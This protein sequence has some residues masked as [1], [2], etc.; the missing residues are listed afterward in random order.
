MSGSH[1]QELGRRVL[2]LVISVLMIILTIILVKTLPVF[3]RQFR[4]DDLSIS[5]PYVPQD[6]VTNAEAALVFIVIPLLFVAFACLA[7]KFL[8]STFSK[9][10]SLG[11]QL[12]SVTWH[13]Y[14]FIV[15]FVMVVTVTLIL[16]QLIKTRVGR[17]RPDFLDRCKPN[18][19]RVAT[20]PPTFYTG[21][22]CTGDADTID[23]GRQSFPSGHAS[24]SFAGMTFLALW[25][26]TLSS[27]LSFSFRKSQISSGVSIRIVFPLA[28]ILVAFFVTITRSEQNV[29]A[30]SDLIWGAI[31]GASVAILAWFVYLVMPLSEA[32]M[33]QRLYGYMDMAE[34]RLKPSKDLT[35][36]DSEGNA[37]DYVPV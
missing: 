29:H 24:S 7:W 32:E 2:D 5:F 25:F 18:V 17:L 22:I 21:S 8:S 33:E 6:I 34:K 27:P 9:R 11:S 30:P 14:N 1:R 23:E 26:Y 12:K 35:M 19:P 10:L 16:T 4:L 28:C 37:T 36:D 15:A 3:E 20:L 31:L 13:F